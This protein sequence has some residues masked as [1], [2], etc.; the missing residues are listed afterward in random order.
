VSQGYLNID[1]AAPS[2][3]LITWDVFTLALR[4]ITGGSQGVW[5][6]TT[7]NWDLKDK[8]GVSV[9]NGLYYVRVVVSAPNNSVTKILKVLVLR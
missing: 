7:L 5:G 4:K 1:V 6:T 3:G 9:A 2:N 8:A